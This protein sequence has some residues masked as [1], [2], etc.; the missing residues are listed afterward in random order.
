MFWTSLIL[1]TSFILSLENNISIGEE[2]SEQ[3][4]YYRWRRILAL[5]KNVLTSL[6]L[7]TSFILSLENNI[8]I[9][10]ETFWTSFILSAGEVLAFGEEVSE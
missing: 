4:L 3:V 1:F 5:E 9:G 8:S 6:I 2:C 10:E 7:F